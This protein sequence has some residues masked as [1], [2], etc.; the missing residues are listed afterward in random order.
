MTKFLLFY[1]SF[2]ILLPSYMR[3]AYLSRKSRKAH[4]MGVFNF[5]TNQGI[6]HEKVTLC[7]ASV[8]PFICAP[9]L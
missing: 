7:P 6:F 4:F 2:T 5:P 3:I 9:W 1:C 8:Q